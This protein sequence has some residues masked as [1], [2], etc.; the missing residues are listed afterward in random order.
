[1]TPS[2]ATPATYDNTNRIHVSSDYSA[3]KIG[4]TGKIRIY[5]SGGRFLD[6]KEKK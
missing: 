2:Y 4:E 6:E 1:M 5:E 3:K